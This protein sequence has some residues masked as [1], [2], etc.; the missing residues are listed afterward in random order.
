MTRIARWTAAGGIAAMA[1]LAACGEG[2]ELREETERRRA[3]AGGA[4]AD[5]APAAAPGPGTAGE[6][7]PRLPAFVLAD[8][9]RVRPE[10]GAEPGA[11][12]AAP[13]PE[14]GGWTAGRRE[15]G[16]PGAG[17][18]TLRD[19]RAGVNEGFDRIV[20]EFA[21]GEVPGY[22]VEYVDRPVRECGSGNAV[23]IAGDGWLSIRLSP[24]RAHDDRGRATVRD[25][26]RALRMPVMR[27]LRFTCDFEAEV[28]I[29]LGV[30][31]PNRFRVFEQL[32]PAR[33]V[34]DV[35]Q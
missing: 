35:R 17:V 22:T 7:P 8:T 10:T 15:V 34:I 2:G 28:E 24:A 3:D 6:A 14:G 5:T 26:Q 1:A 12:E 32:D 11:P 27:E 30:G 4:P 23:E 29:V 18:A 25:R 33:L 20:V 16:R 31:S 13:E 21:G 9:P 19:V